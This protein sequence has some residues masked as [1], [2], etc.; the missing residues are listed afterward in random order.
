[1]TREWQDYKVTAGLATS[2]AGSIWMQPTK[3]TH[4]H[5]DAAKASHIPAYAPTGEHGSTIIDVGRGASVRISGHAHLVGAQWTVD[6]RYFYVD[7]DKGGDATP[8]QKARALEIATA[9]VN[10]WALAH[11]DALAEAERCDRNNGARSLEEDIA[12]HSAAL[13][14]L[15]R[16]L[17]ACDNGRAWTQYPDLPTKR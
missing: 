14:I 16:E 5:F 7:G 17:R 15:R 12:R 1:M 3:A 6:P 8:R 9:M 10:A 13:K 11:P 2:D 4:I